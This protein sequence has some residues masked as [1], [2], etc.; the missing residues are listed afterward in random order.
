[1]TRRRKIV[2]IIILIFGMILIA[3][4]FYILNRH[5]YIHAD[6]KVKQMVE[7]LNF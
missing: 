5:I 2:R 1:M 3:Q 4:I 7:R 6:F